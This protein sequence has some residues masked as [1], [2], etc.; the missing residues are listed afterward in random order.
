MKFLI[1]YIILFGFGFAEDK[2]CSEIRPDIIKFKYEF[3]FSS[4]EYDSRIY[5]CDVYP[6]DIEGKLYLLFVCMNNEEK[7]RKSYIF[8]HKCADEITKLSDIK[9]FIVSTFTKLSTEITLNYDYSSETKKLNNSHS[10]KMFKSIPIPA[11]EIFRY[12]KEI[13]YLLLAR[14][15]SRI[16]PITK[17]KTLGYEYNDIGKTLELSYQTISSPIIYCRLLQNNDFIINLEFFPKEKEY[18][19]C[20]DKDLAREFLK[21]LIMQ[22]NEI[23]D[24]KLPLMMSIQRFK[25]SLEELIKDFQQRYKREN[26]HFIPDVTVVPTKRQ[27]SKM[28]DEVG[29]AKKLCKD[30]DKGSTLP[31]ELQYTPSFNGDSNELFPELQ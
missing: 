14:R 3:T 27:A 28:K 20:Q 17:L 30:S 19:F 10:N 6:S 26:P 25:S 7:S 11:L 15:A 13:T 31:E 8:A 5:D 24:M 9:R 1:F 23:I 2:T 22:Y 4:T 21:T 29:L 18:Y 12:C 16:N